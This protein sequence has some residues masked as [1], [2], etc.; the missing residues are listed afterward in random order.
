MI[1]KLSISNLIT[2]SSDLYSYTTIVSCY[3]KNEIFY[4]LN[5]T[6]ENIFYDYNVDYLQ[7]YLINM[8][9]DDPNIVC[10]EVKINYFGTDIT[11]ALIDKD[12][13]D[14]QGLYTINSEMDPNYIHRLKAMN[15]ELFRNNLLLVYNKMLRR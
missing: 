10:N 5:N 11:D 15:G 3:N 12:I 9:Y 6:F 14:L 8:P 7:V 4:S 2:E 1:Q 13:F